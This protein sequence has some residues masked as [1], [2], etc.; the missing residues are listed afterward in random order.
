MGLGE[1]GW[2]VKRHTANGGQS[3]ETNFTPS[4]L[5]ASTFYDSCMQ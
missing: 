2:L 4:N 5:K 3:Q 1:E